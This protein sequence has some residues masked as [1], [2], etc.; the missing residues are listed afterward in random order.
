ME[1]ILIFAMVCYM[2]PFWGEITFY[3]LIG[4]VMSE[5]RIAYYS[6]TC[7]HSILDYFLEKSQP[8][9]CMVT[10]LSYNSYI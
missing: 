1:K 6:V 4:H 9:G 2:R 3:H 7:K 8:M 10:E 5:I